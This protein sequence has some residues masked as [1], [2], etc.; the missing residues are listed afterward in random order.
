MCTTVTPAAGW[1]AYK[2]M[3]AQEYINSDAL[4][5]TV[6]DQAQ[7]YNRWWRTVLLVG[8]HGGWLLPS[9]VM[10]H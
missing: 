9:Q 7:V 4:D 8:V 6:I 3:V 10:L 5:L 2:F 1:E